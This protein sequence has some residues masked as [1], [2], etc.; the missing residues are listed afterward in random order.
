MSKKRMICPEKIRGHLAQL[1]QQLSLIERAIKQA[2][3]RSE[4]QKQRKF[5][6]ARLRQQ[7]VSEEDRLHLAE[8]ERGARPV[9]ASQ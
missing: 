8:Q 1:R 9:A 6:A 2:P 4:G 7:I 5:D 3:I